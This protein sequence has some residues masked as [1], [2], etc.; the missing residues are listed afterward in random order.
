MTLR[1][2]VSI[3]LFKFG[4]GYMGIVVAFEDRDTQMI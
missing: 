2:C 1:I 4:E 3:G